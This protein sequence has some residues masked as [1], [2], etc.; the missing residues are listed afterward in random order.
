MNRMNAT[1][2]NIERS[3]GDSEL[4][5]ELESERWILQKTDKALRSLYLEIG[6]K[7]DELKKVDVLKSQFVSNVSHEFKNPLGVIRESMDLVFKGKF[8]D[9]QEEQKDVL[10]IGIKTIDRLIRLVTNLLDISKIEAGGMKLN[11]EK[12]DLTLIVEDV[13]KVY[14]LELEKK[15]IRVQ[16]NILK[17]IILKSSDKDKI[18]EVVINLLDNAIRYSSFGGIIG[19]RIREIKDIIRFEISDDGPGIQEENIQSIFNKFESIIGEKKGGAGL[20]LAITKD[21]ISL[22]KGEIWVE[23]EVGRGSKF[24]FTLPKD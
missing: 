16:K 7:N 5:K 8:G 17:K 10:R 11:K 15:M 24:I 19:I 6:R 20:G 9:L 2:K 3:K 22:H 18:T 12:V 13:L 14:K 1:K 21:I 4:K 23:S